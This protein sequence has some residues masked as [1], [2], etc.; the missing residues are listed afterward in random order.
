MITVPPFNGFMAVVTKTNDIMAQAIAR[1]TRQ[2]GS[3]QRVI[4]VVLWLWLLLLMAPGLRRMLT[5]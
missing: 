4:V 3:W 1:Q 5:R 2:L